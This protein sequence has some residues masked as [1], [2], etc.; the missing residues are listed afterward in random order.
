MPN[1]T[2]G[3]VEPAEPPDDAVRVLGVLRRAGINFVVDVPAG[4]APGA[5]GSVSSPLPVRGTIQVVTGTAGEESVGPSARIGI[6]ATVVPAGGGDGLLYLNRTMRDAVGVVEGDE[7]EVSLWPDDGP[8]DVELPADVAEA[9]DAAG[10]RE[11]F[12]AWSP[13]HQREYLVAIEDAKR[14]DTRRRRIE[15]TVAALRRRPPGGR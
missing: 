9:F 2:P 5:V 6:R 10:V 4:S 3:T 1:F 12:T 14:P 13:S 7:L 11:A 15:R 8:R